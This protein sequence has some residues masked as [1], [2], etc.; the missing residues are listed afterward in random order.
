MNSILS[1][2]KKI[3]QFFRGKPSPYDEAVATLHELEQ[4]TPAG[5][6]N[7]AITPV[8]LALSQSCLEG[9]NYDEA[10][11]FG[12][13]AVAHHQGDDKDNLAYCHYTFAYNSK[14]VVG[15]EGIPAQGG[16]IVHENRYNVDKA[17]SHGHKAI[18]LWDKIKGGEVSLKL[19]RTYEILG[20]AYGFIEA[21]DEAITYLKKRWEGG[22]TLYKDPETVAS[23]GDCAYNIG[24]T[25]YKEGK[26]EEAASFFQKALTIY[27]VSLGPSDERAGDAG[28]MLSLCS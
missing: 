14:E 28:R 15:R 3:K 25:Y 16:I 9:Q 20:I 17:L 23:H 6:K 4:A 19:L 5:E 10:I 1:F 13:K 21:Y 12:E 7:P 18:S 8:A 11:T 27:L 24:Q 2:F 22:K 26:R